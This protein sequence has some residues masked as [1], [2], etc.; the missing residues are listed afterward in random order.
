MK[1]I[2]CPVCG[3]KTIDIEDKKNLDYR[4]KSDL[5]CSNCNSPLRISKLSILLLLGLGLIGGIIPFLDISII[6]KVIL[7]IL[8]T[9]L[10][11]YM[12]TY[13]IPLVKDE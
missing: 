7:V 3:E 6:I 12:D 13:V 5:K 2:K 9:I 1:K 8:V 10:Y 4:F 11:F